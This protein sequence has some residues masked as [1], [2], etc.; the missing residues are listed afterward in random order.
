MDP[1]IES[2]NHVDCNSFYSME[3]SPNYI[4]FSEHLNIVQL[5]YQDILWCFTFAKA[6]LFTKITPRVQKHELKIGYHLRVLSIRHQG[7]I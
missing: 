7:Y 2:N 1:Y 6:V 5:Q 3:C 4:K